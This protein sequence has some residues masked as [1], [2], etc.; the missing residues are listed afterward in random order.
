MARILVVDDDPLSLAIMSRSLEKARHDIVACSDLAKAID[1]FAQSECDAVVCALT[2]P[3]HVSMEFIRAARHHTPETVIIAVVA[4]KAHLP[5][6]NPDIVHMVHAIGA[7]E[8]IK[9]PFEV[10]EF[11]ATIE[12]TIALHKQQNTASAAS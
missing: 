6:L 9:K 11:I 1:I 12:R 7:D 8:V 5:Q 10:Q 2:L 3:S 4:G